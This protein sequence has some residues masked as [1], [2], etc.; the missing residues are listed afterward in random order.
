MDKEQISAVELRKKNPST[1]PYYA[2]DFSRSGFWHYTTL[3]TARKILDSECIYASNL[4]SMND[5][6]EICLHESMKEFVHCVCFCNSNTEKIPM[7][8]LYSGISGQG[9]AIRFTPGEIRKLLL[10]IK[11]VTTPEQDVVLYQ[12]K[13]FDLHYGWIYYREPTSHVRIMYRR[14]WYT[15]DDSEQ[16]ET[17]N[18][19]IKAY[20]WEYEKEFRIVLINKTGNP[21]ERLVIDFGNIKKKKEILLGPEYHDECEIKSDSESAEQIKYKKSKLGIKMDLVSRNENILP[22]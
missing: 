8:Y 7:W 12:G 3:D 16:F 5:L 15:V 11:T 22:H 21:Y 20:P 13:D 1:I 17:D 9:A 4:A 14:Q 10:S 2:K 19:F 6:D 18:Y